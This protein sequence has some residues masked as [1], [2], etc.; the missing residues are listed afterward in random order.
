M[1]ILVITQQNSGVG[2]H[3]LMLPVHFMPGV[4]G[5]FTDVYSEQLHEQKFDILFVNRYVPGVELETILE[6]REK[7]GFKLIVDI[8]DYWHLDS[9]HILSSQY[10]TQKIIDHIKA[11]D[12]VT[13]TNELLYSEIK[14]LNE[15]VHILPNALPY[16][17]DQFINVKTESEKVRF[18]YAGSITHEKDVAILRNPLKRV[19]SDAIRGKVEFC[20]CGY[21]PDEKRYMNVWHSMIRDFTCAFKL[22]HTRA[23][24]PVDKYMNFY[25]D[26]DVSLVPLVYS[27][28]NS[29]KSNLKVLEAASRN[30]PVIA[31]NVPPYDNCPILPVNSQPDWFKH[32]KKI[33]VDSIY[34]QEQGLKLSEWAF[35]L[36]NLRIVNI[37]RKQIFESCLS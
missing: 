36:F 10:P 15:N 21:N 30:I 24:L 20:L 14:P 28:F 29:M 34:R 9:W 7:Y 8:D 2:F 17:E 25:N 22:G 26:A 33:T 12:V 31:S 19:A 1:R 3:R 18:I 11:A 6:H 23:A 32:I 16:G 5:L 13:C 4:Y 27:R 37:E 35:Q